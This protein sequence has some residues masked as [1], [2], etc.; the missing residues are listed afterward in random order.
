MKKVLFILLAAMASLASAQTAVVTPGAWDLYRGTSIVSTHPT[1]AACVDAA[2]ALNVTRSYTCRTRTAVAVTAAAPVPTCPASPPP[3]ETQTIACPAGTTGLW[4][5]TRSYAS[6]PYPT[7]WTPGAWS[8]SAAPAGACTTVVTPPPV[9]P[10]ATGTNA[11]VQQGAVETKVVTTALTGTTTYNV[12]SIEDARAVPWGSLACGSMVN[13]YHAAAA[14]PIKI[15]LRAQCP[16]SNPVVINGVSN[17]AG[18]KPVI[19]CAGATTMPGSANVFSDTPAY[20]ESLGCFVVKR[21]NADAYA[22]AKPSGIVIQGLAFIG[23]ANGQ[24]YTA[25]NGSTQTFGDAAS[26]YVHVGTDITVQNV[27]ATDAAFCMFVMAKD[28][29]L[30]H[31]GERITLRNSRMSGCGV[32]GQYY[33]H[34]VYM[35]AASPIVEGNFFGKLKAGGEGSSYKTRSSGEVFRNNYVIATARALDFVQSED[36]EQ[37]IAAQPSYATDWVYGNTI[38]SDGPEAIHY[39]GDNLG[40]QEQ[41]GIFVPTKPYRKN[42][43][44]WNNKVTLQATSAWWRFNVFDLSLSTT[45]AQVWGN[46]FTLGGGRADGEGV[47]WLQFA[48]KLNLGQNTIIGKQPS[49]ARFDA[50]PAAWSITTGNAPPTLPAG[51]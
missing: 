44:F 1:E 38:V 48:G 35:Q 46:T 17:A 42:L 22:G 33:Q 51:L 9:T 14:Y 5:Q 19:Q 39:G 32:V 34:N 12:Q 37:G 20:G 4:V 8:P 43:Y 47:S 15:G 25:L 7:C 3:P 49:N 21:G 2:K 31:A 45:T 23:A 11:G 28:G 29:T 16:S 18:D 10:P 13:V 27:T 40:E 26:I 24:K 36:N 50:N 6:A 30:N 41:T